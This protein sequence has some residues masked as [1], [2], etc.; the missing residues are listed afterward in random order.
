MSTIVAVSVPA[1]LKA[2]LDAE[3]KRQRR[4]RS[5]VVAEAVRAYL[6]DRG[7]AAFAE[8][9]DRTLQEG[10]ALALPERIALSERLWQELTF[11]RK[12]DRGY[13]ASF[14]TF[15]EYEKWRRAGGASA[16]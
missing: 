1:D 2:D 16:R 8:A 4:S 7:E 6:V 12:P 14:D 5:F 9:T 13:T 11:G 10:L 15:D 3:A